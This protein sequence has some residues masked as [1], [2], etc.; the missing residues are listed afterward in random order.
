MT[1]CL[2]VYNEIVAKERRRTRRLTALQAVAAAAQLVDFIHMGVGVV[3]G[4]SLL[5]GKWFP[6]YRVGARESV[7]ALI[8]DSR[9]ALGWRRRF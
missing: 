7:A 6:H 1:R 2:A 5:A 9:E 8:H 4:A 3:A